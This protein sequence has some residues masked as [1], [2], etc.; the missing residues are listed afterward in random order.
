MNINDWF[1][2]QKTILQSI[3]NEDENFKGDAYISLAIIYAALAICN[4][5]APSAISLCGPRGAM[6]IGS[7]AYW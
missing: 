1:D 6:F 3:A 7:F 4:W 5:L 2:Q